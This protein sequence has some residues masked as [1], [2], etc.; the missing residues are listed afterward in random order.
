MLAS[1]TT[2]HT[3]V[4]MRGLILIL[5]SI[6]L[7]CFPSN[8]LAASL[9]AC[10]KADN[11]RVLIK[12]RCNAKK[13]QQEINAEILQGLGATQVGPQG[14]Q[15]SQGPK[16]QQGIQGPSGIVSTVV[17]SER[18][19]SSSSLNS[20]VVSCEPGEIAISGGHSASGGVVSDKISF[21]TSTP[22][23]GNGPAP[24]GSVPN[25]WYTLW[26]NFSGNNLYF[27]TFVVCAILEQ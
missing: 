12:R 1:S 6:T 26:V 5:L 2:V 11:G 18:I 13:G 3:G 4:N 21:L 23:E 19:Q 20:S 7:V 27:T 10:L 16:G 25:G 24:D 9:K 15:G 14:P 17:R 8:S 22:A